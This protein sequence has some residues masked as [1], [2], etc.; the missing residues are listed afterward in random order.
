MRFL[1]KYLL[2]LGRKGCK[3]EKKKMAFVDETIS[4]N[5]SKCLGPTT[6]LLLKINF[7]FTHK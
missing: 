2:R 3:E 6:V 7:I 1:G 4:Y 5:F